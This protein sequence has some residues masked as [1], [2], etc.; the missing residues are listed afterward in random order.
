MTSERQRRAYLESHDLV[1]DDGGKVGRVVDV[2]HV[3]ESKII[4]DKDDLGLDG[5]L[6]SSDSLSDGWIGRL[7]DDL[8]LSDDESSVD[9]GIPIG[10]AAIDGYILDSG[11]WDEPE[12][13]TW[14][15]PRR[16]AA[17]GSEDGSD[18]D[19]EPLSSPRPSGE[20]SDR[21][22]PDVI[23]PRMGG[24]C[25][26]CEELCI[27]LGNMTSLRDAL[28]FVCSGGPHRAVV[29]ARECEHPSQVRQGN[30]PTLRPFCPYLRGPMTGDEVKIRVYYPYF[31]VRNGEV[32]SL[33]DV[34]RPRRVSAFHLLRAFRVLV[35]CP[36]LQFHLKNCGNY[37]C[38]SS[39]R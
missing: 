36:H 27:D 8:G 28:R 35:P 5:S 22:A 2:V 15:I 17:S 12:V 20:C 4:V 33:W 38:P 37:Y 13:A 1:Q 7:G 21:L 25:V 32:G 19:H 26:A 9:E 14:R 11:L 39:P 10:E 23:V 6:C 30:R 29:D 24:S 18:G 16:R 34:V 31:R 3:P